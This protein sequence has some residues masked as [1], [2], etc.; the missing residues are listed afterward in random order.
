MPFID[1]GNELYYRRW[2]TEDPRA[3]VVFLHGFGEHGGHYHRFAHDLGAQRFEVWGLDLPGHGLSSG[4]RGD[5][6]SVEAIADGATRL[7]E[8]ARRHRP[9][10]PV[11]LIGHS[12]GGVTA[13]LM[14]ARGISVD[15]VVLTGTPLSGLPA[16][17]A[18]EPVMSKDEFYLDALANDPLGFDTAPAEPALWSNISGCTRELEAGLSL[19]AIPTLFVNG[20]RDAFAPVSEARYWAA[21]MSHARVH[22]IRD[23]HHDILNDLQHREVSGAISRFITQTLG[24]ERSVPLEAASPTTV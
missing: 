2:S 22:R 3:A 10:L 21:R 12:L 16:H 5:F 23:G 13:A 15:A 7:L 18:E 14:S 9:T 11:V 17:V 4:E 1:A 19:S 24:L 6:G 8:L 20:D